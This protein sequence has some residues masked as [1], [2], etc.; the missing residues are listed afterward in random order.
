MRIKKRGKRSKK[1]KNVIAKQRKQ[2]NKK[3]G[4]MKKKIEYKKRK[5]K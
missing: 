2:N 1:N 4:K 5:E 3:N